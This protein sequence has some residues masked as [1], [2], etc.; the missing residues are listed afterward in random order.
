[1]VLKCKIGRVIIPDELEITSGNLIIDKSIKIIFQHFIPVEASHNY[2]NKTI[3]YVGY[4]DLFRE[5]KEG[6]EIPEYEFMVTKSGLVKA[7]EK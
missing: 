7:T 5:V 6:C 2:C 1:M 4:S 3:K